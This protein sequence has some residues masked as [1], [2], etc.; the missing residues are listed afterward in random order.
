MLW[1]EDYKRKLMS[2]DEAL[3]AVESDSRIF[4][5]ANGGYPQV[6]LEALARRGPRVRDVEV[7]HILGFGEP[8]Y[9]APE[10][11]ESFRHNAMFIGGNTREAVREGRADYNPIHLSEIEHLFSSGEMPLDVALI[12]VAPPDRFGFCNLG[13]AVEIALTAA[14]HARYVIAQ[15]NDRM[16]RTCGNNFLH[17]REIDAFVECSVPLP[18]IISPPPTPEHAAIARNVA[19]LIEDGCC[20]QTGI[21]GIPDAILPY[22]ADRRD[23]GV[24]TETLLEGAIPLVENGVINGRR[25]QIDPNK[26][27]LGF[28]LGTDRMYDF[29]RENP[30]FQFCPSSYTNDPEIIAQNDNVVAINSAIEVDITGQVCSDSMGTTFFSGFGGQLDFIRGAAH[31]KGGKPIIALPSTAKGGTVSRIVPTLT[32]GAGVV[33]TRGDVYYV[34]TEYGVAYLHGKNIRQ[35][36]EALIQ[37]AHPKFR[38]ELYDHCEKMRW[39]QKSSRAMALEER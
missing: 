25:K 9:T 26:I 2:A 14:R 11:E 24:H 20:L 22:L 7:V 37:I 4:V 34:A 39:L 23:L 13:V 29:V 35:R 38:D 16:P 33:T 28:A 32:Y 18:Q 1:Q 27:V 36:A 17:V 31:S 5:Q 10:L 12:H 19:P 30:I 3:R 6:L 15:V 21:G 8:H